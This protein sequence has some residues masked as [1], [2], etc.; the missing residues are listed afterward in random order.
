MD[1]GLPDLA[2]YHVSGCDRAVR[3]YVVSA[4]VVRLILPP[5]GD[6][7]GPSDFPTIAFRFVVAADNRADATARENLELCNV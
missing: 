1:D 7:G 4:E 2:C 3:R 6:F 5:R